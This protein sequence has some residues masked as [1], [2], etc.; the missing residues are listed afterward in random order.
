MSATH[1]Q[2]RIPFRL[3][4]LATGLLPLAAQADFIDDSSGRLDLRNFYQ[5]RDYRQDNAAQS[6]AGNWSQAFVLR[7]QSGFTEGP[8]G[9]G[10]DATGLLGVKLDSG[11]GRSGDGT[12]PFG[13]NSREPV[14]E[15]SHA[16]LTA[17][18]RYSKT[19]LNIGLLEPQLPVVFRDDVRLMPQ[20]FDGALLTSNEID[21]LTL[22]AG[23]LWK[24]RTRES[25]GNDDM[26]IMGRSKA[27]ASDEF[28]LAGASYAFT[29]NLTASYF[30]GQLKDIYQQHYYGLVHTLP[31]AEGLSLRS[32]LRYFD[33]DDDG[34]AISGPVDNRNL[35]MMFTLRAGAHAIGVA[36]QKMI[37]D[38]GFPTLNGYT[39][40]YSHNLM[41][42]QTFTQPGEKSWQLR[43]DYDFA[44]L[45]VPGLS[46][47]TRYTRG[48]DIR[49]GAGLEDGHEYERDSDLAYTLQDGPLKG[50]SLRWRNVTARSSHGADMDENRLIANYSIPIW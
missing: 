16:G 10:L 32:D 41:T 7:L 36:Y 3:G 40:P 9:F 13:P 42:I 30:Y 14:D 25:A 38:D 5:L 27:F 29:P 1:I 26:Y 28:N 46:F 22:T 45:G 31:L 35:S 15:Y 21:G 47:M 19:Q 4:L 37:G 48:D 17:K 8:I 23:Q 2:K 11:R 24:S 34:K 20:T 39:P 50:L 49:R 18:L 44:S 12:L 43:Y 6:Q 33:S